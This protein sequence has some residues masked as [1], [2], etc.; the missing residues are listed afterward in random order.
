MTYRNKYKLVLEQLTDFYCSGKDFFSRR[1]AGH[2]TRCV[3]KWHI[4][5]R[6]DSAGYHALQ[7]KG[8]EY[9]ITV[10]TQ[11]HDGSQ[12]FIRLVE[13]SRGTRFCCS[14]IAIHMADIKWQIW[15]FH[16]ATNREAYHTCPKLAADLHSSYITQFAY[17]LQ[18][19]TLAITPFL[20]DLVTR[21]FP[22]RRLA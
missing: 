22:R 20:T 2:M 4:T 8:R 7:Y 19:N 9:R 1:W 13:H 11:L 10:V 16:I 21:F 6:D 12:F 17:F 14:E 15:T 5:T 18:V 3:I